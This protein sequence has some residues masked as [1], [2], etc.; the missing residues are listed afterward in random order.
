MINKI[1]SSLRRS[2]RK[3]AVISTIL[4]SEQ[5]N[6][7]VVTI[8]RLDTRNV[9]DLYCAPHHYFE[10]LKGTQLDIFDYKSEDQGVANNFIERISSN[11]L[12][13]GGGGLL[14]RNGFGKQMKLFEQL[15]PKGKKTVLWG[16]G[17]NAKSPA[18]YGKKID[19]NVDISKFGLAGTRDYSMPGEYVPCVS[20]MHPIFDKEY[21]ET[22]DTGIVFHK[23]TL[24]KPKITGRFGDFPTSSNTTNFEELIN[25][26]G[27][28]N[29]IVTDSYHAM[30]WSMLMGKKVVAIPNSSKFYDFK[31]KPVI[32]T[33]NN[34]IN[35]M[36]KAQVYTGLLEECRDINLKF[37]EKVFDYLKL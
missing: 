21:T 8:H 25:F 4:A 11:S 29:K 17:H 27:S 35:D 20:C 10:Q 12:I 30:Y 9:G 15:G 37:S 26:I 13:I 19:Y 24:R 33:F 31:E 18:T 14:N 34:A 3:R 28:C 2:E 16:V 7:G 22:E 5:K 6:Q 32:S 1:L 23:D 36:A